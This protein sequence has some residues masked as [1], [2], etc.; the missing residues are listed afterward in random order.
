MLDHIS[1]SD[2]QKL[3]IGL[4]RL[5]T[6]F[7]GSPE[8]HVDSVEYREGHTKDIARLVPEAPD[9]VFHLGEFSRTAVAIEE[10]EKVWDLNL[11][12]TYNV[13]EYC[14]MHNCKIVYA[15]SS[16][17]HAP[18][19]MVDGIA[20]RDLSPYTWAKGSQYRDGK[21]LWSL[22]RITICNYLL[23]QCVWTWRKSWSL[24]NCYRNF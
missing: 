10:P 23:L 14:R 15:G 5:I 6:I 20:G 1:V 11:L 3:A 12:G 19:R 16:T 17:K 13:L 4:F 18:V 2:W 8:N 7:T 21:E 24:W 22:V 9:M